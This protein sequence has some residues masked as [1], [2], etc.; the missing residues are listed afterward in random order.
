MKKVF[1]ILSLIFILLFYPV[2]KFS[3]IQMYKLKVDK[4][5]Y[6]K[7]VSMSNDIENYQKNISF[8]YNNEND[9]KLNMVYLNGK[10]FRVRYGDNPIVQGETSYRDS[11][12]RFVVI[13]TKNDKYNLWDVF[14]SGGDN[15]CDELFANDKNLLCISSN[16]NGVV[17][18]II[19]LDKSYTTKSLLS[20]PINIGKYFFIYERK[21]YFIFTD[22]RFVWNLPIPDDAPHEFGTQLLMAGELDINTLNFKEYLIGYADT[23]N[24]ESHSDTILI[25]SIRQAQGVSEIGNTG[26]FIIR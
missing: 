7:I 3:E 21:M 12:T 19:N 11:T 13:E 20:T 18:K 15:F 1:I 8:A 5:L 16:S 22:D 26:A 23:K 25:P 10:I 17:L 4:R 2:Y 14:L 9:D 24:Y 6:D